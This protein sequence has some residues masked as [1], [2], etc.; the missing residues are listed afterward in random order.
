[1]CRILHSALVLI[2]VAALVAPLSATNS[3][4]IR[5]PMCCLGKGE[6]K[7]LGDMDSSHGAPPQGFSRSAEKCP[8]PPLALAARHGPELARPIAAQAVAV[9][10]HRVPVILETQFSAFAS[11]LQARSERGPPASSPD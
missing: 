1:M 11:G 6:H 3:E 9:D 5:A 2:L 10:S 7:C 8:Y 4:A